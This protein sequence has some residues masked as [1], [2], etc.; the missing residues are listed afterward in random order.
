MN[1]SWMKFLSIFMILFK[2]SILAQSLI[3]CKIHI[4]HQTSLHTSNRYLFKIWNLYGK[5]ARSVDRDSHLTSI[6]LFNKILNKESLLLDSIW[7]RTT[8]SEDFFCFSLP[9]D[10]SSSSFILYLVCQFMLLS[11]YEINKKISKIFFV[12][13]C[14][15]FLWFDF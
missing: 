2:L 4:Y 6:D 7:M 13:Y 8:S 15:N 5:L 3:R 10:C 14:W 1:H 9:L 12:C 11:C